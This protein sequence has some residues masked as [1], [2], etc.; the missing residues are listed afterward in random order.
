M[1]L[2]L[3]SDLPSRIRLGWPFVRIIPGWE[4]PFLGVWMHSHL[5]IFLA[6]HHRDMTENLLK[7]LL[8]QTTHTDKNDKANLCLYS[9]DPQHIILVDEKLIH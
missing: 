9:G 6:K 4:D 1:L 5:F 3:H 2:A 7:K 8:T